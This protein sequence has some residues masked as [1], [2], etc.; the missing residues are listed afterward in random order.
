MI[1]L[2]RLQCRRQPNAD[3]A[4]VRNATLPH[5]TVLSRQFLASSLRAIFSRVRVR[6]C[7]SITILVGT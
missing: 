5:L 4:E 6:V 7:P 3:A 1:Q 2:G